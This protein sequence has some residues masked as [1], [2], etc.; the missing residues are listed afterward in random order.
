MVSVFDVNGKEIEKIELPKVFSTPVRED[1]IL[2]A[3]LAIQSHKRQPYGPNEL[4]G[5][6]TSA[7]YH[8][9]RHSRYTMMNREIARHQ[10]LH[11]KTVPQLFWQ[12]RIAPQTKGGR[13]AHPPLPEKNWY[14]K[15]NEKERIK[16]I[17]SA[18]TATSIKEYVK[19]RGHKVDDVKE[20]PI[21]VDDKIQEIKKT[22]EIVEFL[23]K[24]GLEKE[25]ER[26]K[27]KKIRAGK[28]K[29]RGRKYKKKV[30]I[31]FVVA[32]DKGIGKAVKNLSGCEVINFKDLSVEHLAP[33]GKAGR[34]TI[35]T[36]SA[37]LKLGEKYGSV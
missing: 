9:E 7:H 5:L 10:R 21:I 27:E 3:F 28:G 8:G 22:K 19:A 26:V 1:L 20:L 15:I 16:A 11:G 25:L 23:K 34:L 24:V 29:M 32:E 2:R 35:F 36:K 30:G 14:Q 6:R 33:G 31:L 13:P 4:S 18:I 37:I 12:A 17:L